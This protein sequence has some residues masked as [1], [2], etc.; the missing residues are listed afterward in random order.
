MMTEQDAKEKDVAPD[1]QL[2]IEYAK[3]T[4]EMHIK[5]SKEL[6]EKIKTAKTKTKAKYFSK[7]IARNNMELMKILVALEKLGVKKQKQK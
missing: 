2:M 7:K 4:L 3:K 1:K 5:K 6:Q